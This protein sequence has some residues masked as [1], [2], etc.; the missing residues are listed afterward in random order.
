MVR[1]LRQLVADQMS[2]LFLWKGMN[3]A[4]VEK[5]HATVKDCLES[6]RRMLKDTLARARLQASR[7]SGAAW[8]LQAGMW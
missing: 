1:D 4:V 7:Q 2:E 5:R 8:R 3:A 6:L